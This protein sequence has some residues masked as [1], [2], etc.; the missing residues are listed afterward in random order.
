MDTSALLA[1]GRNSCIAILLF[2]ASCAH[3]RHGLVYFNLEKINI[4]TT[5]GI[6]YV[7][8]KPL[9]GIV[10]SLNAHGDTTSVIPYYEGKENGLCRYYFDNGKPKSFRFYV[11]GWKEGEHTGWFENGSQQFRFHFEND[12]FEGNQKEWLASGQLYSDLNYHAGMERGSQKV[13]NPDGSIKTN[14]II[15]NDRRYGLLGTKNC[16]NVVDSVFR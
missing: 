4:A 9:T 14:Y 7:D 12:K 2:F 11:N 16:V 3:D 10:Y 5:K 8:S 1:H 6:A 13:W 15:I